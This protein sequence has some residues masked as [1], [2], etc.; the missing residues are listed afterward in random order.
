MKQ[1]AAQEIDMLNGGLPLAH[2]IMMSNPLI[3]FRLTRKRVAIESAQMACAT[4]IRT[5]SS[6]FVITST[7]LGGSC[8]LV[9]SIVHGPSA[10]LHIHL[11][12]LH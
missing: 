3:Q 12:P 5:P 9:N 6:K 10:V 4:D 7:F 8:P 1:K 11:E 2:F